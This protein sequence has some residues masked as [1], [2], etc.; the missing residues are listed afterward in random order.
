M[1]CAPRPTISTFSS[2]SI[3]T[4]STWAAA[5]PQFPRL[6]HRLLTDD[7]PRRLE[8]AILGLGRAQARQTR[9]LAAIA[10]VLAVLVVGILWRAAAG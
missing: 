5:F 4:S 10:V 6:V 3:S 2:P 8:S 1:T 7:A 9:V